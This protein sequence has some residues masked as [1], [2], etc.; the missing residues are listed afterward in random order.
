MLFA[1]LL[2]GGLEPAILRC[3][4]AKTLAAVLMVVLS[5]AGRAEIL[6][7]SRG[8]ADI[9]YQ[10]VDGR[11]S[12]GW[13][14]E[15]GD[16]LGG[17]FLSQDTF[18]LPG[19]VYARVADSAEVFRAA[20]GGWDVLGVAEGEA[21]F[22]LPARSSPDLP[23]LGLSTDADPQAF[24]LRW[25]LIDHRIPTG[26]NFT[27]YTTPG[28]G[29]ISALWATSDLERFN[30]FGMPWGS[31]NHYN[32]AFTDTGVY[33]L[34]L[35]LSGDIDGEAFA[36]AGTFRFVV[37]SSTAVPEPSSW[38]LMAAAGVASIAAPRLRRRLLAASPLNG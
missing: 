20:G 12:L 30:N 5:P 26:A 25:T 9:G 11:I 8:H 32:W 31:H 36:A 7:Y 24:N 18:K 22:R 6:E 33:D 29:Q 23:H 15:E 21:Y 17:Q 4:A 19:Q 16:E 28:I 27:L 14:F 10:M 38:W 35:Q 13:K 3:C 37:G 1:N 2:V 34:T